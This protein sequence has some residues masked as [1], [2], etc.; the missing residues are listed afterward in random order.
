MSDL[1]NCPLCGN[2]LEIVR[3]NGSK[4]MRCISGICIFE[5]ARH[6]YHI[7]DDELIKRCNR[8]PAEDALR[9]RNEKLVETVSSMEKTIGKAEKVLG[10]RNLLAAEVE[11]LKAALKRI[12]YYRDLNPDM[13]A[14]E[15][16]VDVESELRN[17][18]CKMGD[19]AKM[20]LGTENE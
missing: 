2:L 11:R 1:K 15:F 3:K 20:A 16:A 7:S 12:A 14:T 9:A 4:Y 10:E 19:I 18:Y 6:G 17:F 5:T 8:R 13:K